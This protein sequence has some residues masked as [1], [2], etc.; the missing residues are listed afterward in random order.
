MTFDPDTI[1]PFDPVAPGDKIGLASPASPSTAEELAAGLDMLRAQGFDLEGNTLETGPFPYLAGPD[2]SRAAELTRLMA[3]PELKAV[4]CLRGGYGSLR[5]APLIEFEA[6]AARAKPLIG[7][8]DVTVLLAGLLKAGRASI[9]GPSVR[10]L[11]QESPA[12]LERLTAILAGR[13]AEVEPLAG[14]PA[15]GSGRAEG[16]LV[17]GNLTVL[18]HLIGTP[19]QPPTEGGIVFIE[20]TGEEPYRLD[21]GLTHLLTAGFFDGCAGVAVGRLDDADPDEAVELVADRLAGLKV[22]VLAGLPFGHRPDNM[23]LLVGGRAAIDLE[24]KTLSPLEGS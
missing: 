4:F 8:S 16:Y 23:A 7:F 11:G 1:K 19:W 6:L 21:R 10:S 20:D 18:C 12:S 14:R 9:H 13:W 22:P 5:I 17:G 24:E 15:A 3:D 2:E